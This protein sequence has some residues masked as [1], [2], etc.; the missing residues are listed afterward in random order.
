MAP[1]TPQETDI[2][3]YTAGTPNG[4]KISITLEELGVKYNVNKVDIAK[5]VQKEDWFL[6]INREYFIVSISPN[7]KLSTNHQISSSSPPPPQ[8]QISNNFFLSPANGRIPAIV[9]KTS[10]RSGKPVFEGSSIQ[11]YL[12]AKYDPEHRISFPY[13]SDEYWEVVEWMTWM[14]SGLGPMQGQANHFYRYAPTRMEYA[15]NRYQTETKRLYQV[16]EERLKMQSGGG[17]KVCLVFILS[18]L[19]F[20]KLTL[21][22]THYY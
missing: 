8:N 16:L 3:L 14:Q 22:P 13:D 20:I 18:Y 10:R 21:P 12:T 1:P 11:L 19:H 9:D 5:N 6:K 15:I 4:Q 2:E 17:K 7:P